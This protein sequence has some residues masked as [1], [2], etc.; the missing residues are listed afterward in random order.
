MIATAHSTLQSGESA[1]RGRVRL[2]EAVAAGEAAAE[3][4]I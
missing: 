1:G 4:G 3:R 2:A